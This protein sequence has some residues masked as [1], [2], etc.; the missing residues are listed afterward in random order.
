MYCAIYATKTGD[1]ILFYH[2]GGVDVGDVDQKASFIDVEIDSMPCM[3]QIESLLKLVDCDKKKELISSFIYE[4]YVVYRDLYFT[5]M[6]INPLVIKNGKVYVLDLAAKIDQVE[7][8]LKKNRKILVFKVCRVSVLASV[9]SI[10][11]SGSVWSRRATRGK[12]HCRA[13]R[14]VWIFIKVKGSLICLI[15]RKI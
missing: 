6:E 15:F 12:V 9:G 7:F 13:R 5:Y 1:R 3:A 4:L 2:Q 10:E 11:F 8:N 14:Q